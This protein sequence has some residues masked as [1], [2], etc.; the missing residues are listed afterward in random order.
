MTWVHLISTHWITQVQKSKLINT[1]GGRLSLEPF[2]YRRNGSELSPETTERPPPVTTVTP[3]EIPESRRKI[4]RSTVGQRSSRERRRKWRSRERWGEATPA[5]SCKKYYRGGW[6]RS[7]RWWYVHDD[8]KFVWEELKYS[9]WLCVW[10]REKCNKSMRRCC[11]WWW[12]GVFM[13]LLQDA[14]KSFDSVFHRGVIIIIIVGTHPA[15][16]PENP[17][18]K[19]RH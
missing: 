1:Q 5:G 11:G 12:P 8:I 7:I 16:G 19:K 18:L 9:V 4:Q 13:Q 3:P 15:T 10:E 6:R 2:S 17:N 14:G